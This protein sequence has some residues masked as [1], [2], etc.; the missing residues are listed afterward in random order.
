MPQIGVVLWRTGWGDLLGDPYESDTRNRLLRIMT[1]NGY[2]GDEG[3][4]LLFV[5]GNE[6]AEKALDALGVDAREVGDGYD[7]FAWV[8]EWTFRHLCGYQSD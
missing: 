2:D 4:P 5:Q 8:D 6:E 3:T 1:S 7:H